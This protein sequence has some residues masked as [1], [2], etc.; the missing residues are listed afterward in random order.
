MN[1]GIVLFLCARGDC[2]LDEQDCALDA[3]GW[4][5][6]L[7]YSPLAGCKGWLLFIHPWM[8]TKW[9]LYIYIHPWL[10]VMGSY[11]KYSIL[12]VRGSFG[13]YTPG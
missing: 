1:F 7:Q 6:Y 13:L 4:L 10:D 3:K 11:Y 2:A 8:N 12:Y 5:F 9:W